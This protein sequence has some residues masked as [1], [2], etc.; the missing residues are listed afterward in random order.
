MLLAAGCTLSAAAC[1]TPAGHLIAA[2]SLVEVRA[3]TAS[4]WVAIKPGYSFCGGDQIAVRGDGRAAVVLSNDVLVRLD[5]NS[6]LTL[7][8]VAA[9]RDSRLGLLDGIVHVISRFRKRFGVSTP[10]VNALVE[11]TEFTVASDA[12]KTRVSV[13]EGHVRTVNDGGE[14]V[15]GFGESA[16][17]GAGTAPHGIVVRPLDAISWAIHYPQMVWLDDSEISR[18]GGA[19]GADIRRA[20]DAATNGRYSEALAAVPADGAAQASPRLAAFRA[21]LLLALGRPDAAQADIAGLAGSADSAALEAILAVVSN[22]NDA[23]LDAAR[24]AVAADA[25]S[26]S[27]QLALSYTLQAR[28]QINEALAAAVRGTEL[29]P[30]NPVAWAR[31][32]ELELSLGQLAAGQSSAGRALELA[33]TMPRARAMLGIGQLLSRDSAAALG[34]L[35]VAVA[36]DP[37]DPLAHFGLGLVYVHRNDIARGRREV[38]IAV[39][40]D[41]TNAELRSYL[42]RAY[43]EEKRSR[44][45]GAEFDLAR[46]LDPASPTP[47]YFDALRKLRDGDPVGA[48]KDSEE[49]ITRNDNRAVLRSTELV[50]QDR[51]A[52]SANLGEAYR[53]IGFAGPLLD[54]ARSALADDLRSPAAHRLL[55]DAYAENPRSEIARVSELLQAELRQPIGQWPIAPQFVMPLLPVLQGSRALSLDETTAL[56]DSKPYRFAAS[57]AAGEQATLGNSLLAARAWDRGQLSFGEFNYRT[58]GFQQGADIHLSGNRITAQFAATTETT[59]IAELRQSRRAG[60]DVTQQLVQDLAAPDKRQ[61]VK[62]DIA[63][64]GFRRK[65]SENEEIVGTVTINQRDERTMNRLF[66]AFPDNSSLT[67]TSETINSDHGNDI[68][69]QY[70]GVKPWYSLVAGANSFRSHGDENATSIFELFGMGQVPPQV[71]V[72]TTPRDVIHESA[73]TYLQSRIDSSWLVNAGLS[74]HRYQQYN[75]VSSSRF[76]GKFGFSF[77][78][79]NA[80]TLRFSVTQQIKGFIGEEQTLEPTQFDGFNQL[81][82][83]FN[84]TRSTRKTIAYDHRFTNGVHGGAEFSL[85][86][87]AVPDLLGTGTAVFNDWHERLHD[88]YVTWPINRDI[89]LSARWQYESYSIDDTTALT[90][91]SVPT[92]V[93]TALLPIGLWLRVSEGITLQPEVV[94]IR[95]TS[96]YEN[97]GSNIS[98]SVIGKFTIANLRSAFQPK[99]SKWTLQLEAHNLFDRHFRFQNTDLNGQPR[100]PLFYPVRSIVAQA[101]FR[102]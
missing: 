30:T 100:I 81:F 24:R 31:R 9:D 7:T 12:T 102:F 28:R 47:W 32:A 45:A 51:A 78:P 8:E 64:L 66:Y 38:E 37:A 33:P 19:S 18:I 11:G 26:V 36:S 3:T 21:G 95:Q 48:V 87:L 46:R 1:D 70:V 59:I 10:F 27:A 71:D 13:D 53:E 15:L 68:S 56:F 72:S 76:Y 89:A 88:A 93:R 98:G 63:R 82:D 49:A 29:T 54:A 44:V 41:P 80:S 25:N 35:E 40:L 58:D 55:A 91:S 20:R 43:L 75:G 69:L 94:S 16:E 61:E 99:D 86:K 52:R 2:D 101:S 74:Y 79:S 67:Y 77:Q 60:G 57:V 50:D 85:R 92:A 83:D 42:G 23:A 5:R 97:I 39:L 14:H 73:Y 34:T 22:Q 6:T 17:A 4:S 84:G 62:S 96:E 90:V 65:L